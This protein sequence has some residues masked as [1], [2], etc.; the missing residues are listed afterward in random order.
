M[1]HRLFSP[2]SINF[3]KNY[4]KLYKNNPENCNDLYAIVMQFYKSALSFFSLI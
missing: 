1:I 3:C 4:C 2:Y